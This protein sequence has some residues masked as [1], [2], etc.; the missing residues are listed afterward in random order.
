MARG[1]ESDQ[2]QDRAEA[3]GG[4]SYPRP[5]PRIWIGRDSEVADCGGCRIWPPLDPCSRAGQHVQ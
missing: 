3:Q 2:A 1:R 5:P 4:S